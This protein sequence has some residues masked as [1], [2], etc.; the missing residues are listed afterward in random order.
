MADA[1]GSLTVNNFSSEDLDSLYVDFCCDEASH[2]A[3]KRIYVC[4]LS[5]FASTRAHLFQCVY[6]TQLKRSVGPSFV[7]SY[8]GTFFPYKVSLFT[9]T[10]TVAVLLSN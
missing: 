6:R 4:N 8:E 7:T 2:P 5:V 1:K 3:R 10:V 9:H